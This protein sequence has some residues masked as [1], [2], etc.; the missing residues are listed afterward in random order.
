MAYRADLE[1]QAPFF[2]ALELLGAV[3]LL[4]YRARAF[5]LAGGILPELA[6]GDWLAGYTALACL[7]DGLAL[8][9]LLGLLLVAWLLSPLAG[10]LVSAL[11]L[12]LSAVGIAFMLFAADF[13][14]VYQTAFS[15]SFIGGE[16]FTGLKS[17]LQS[18]GSELSTASRLL[19]LAMLT[20]LALVAALAF[21]RR[22][23]ALAGALFRF[24]K[25]FS[26]LALSLAVLVSAVASGL[27]GQLVADG[28]R[29]SG[30]D[31]A[32]NPLSALLYGRSP[33]SAATARAVAPPAAPDERLVVEHARLAAYN[34]D[35]L[36]SP[37]AERYLPTLPKGPY[38]VILYF[39]E[40]T[41]WRYWDL[42]FGGQKLL[43]TMH[44]LAEHGLLLRNHY[45]NFPLSAN[46]MYSVLSSR[47][48]MYGKSMIF[49][50]YHDI[51][52]GTMMEVLSDN[53]Y[54]TGL[55]HT[56]DLQYAARDDFIAG[57]G[58]DHVV[59]YADLKRGREREA[60]V[61]WGA[62][63]RLMIEP[64]AEW[65]AGRT[66]P[67]FL[68][69]IPVNPHH[70]YAVPD[71]FPRLVD[72]DAPGLSDSERNWRNYL[73]SLHFADAAMGQLVDK[74]EK[75]G[76]MDNTVF[77]MVT[78][79]GEA[80]YQHR[81]NYNH[82]LFIYEENVHV[83]ALF[84]SPSLFPR[85]LVL[86]SVT[87]HV[88]IMPSL[89]DLLRIPDNRQRDGESIFSRSRQKMAVFHTAWNEEFMGVRDGRWKYIQRMADARDELYDL[90]AD[91]DEIQNLAG[92]YP[93]ITARYRQ[94]TN[95]M[96]DYLV[97]QY[98]DPPRR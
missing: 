90:S 57:R 50:E 77:V 98:R 20:S 16:H 40:S 36:E 14:R 93:E 69:V 73:N 67:Y 60:N 10:R 88:D 27:S 94:V 59:L 5:R 15:R 89:L 37:Q 30:A 71:D 46:T 52:V 70:P 62:D 61:G 66:T 79:H 3:S 87:R 28:F 1:R 63:E 9:S 12:A 51:D 18:A 75:R 41:S 17:I 19:L 83:P 48:S 95:G 86:E 11:A 91:P 39:F 47:Y 2:L 97:D 53:G 38:N 44:R 56:G 24:K 45:S 84:Y 43:P 21:S 34:T 76:A 32:A 23:A 49:G 72:A 13:L 8:A 64:A 85:P 92:Q 96:V 6:A 68:M 35:S 81:G 22:M 78:D 42:E 55:I 25:V 82:P 74:L 7:S 65:I 26:L 54:A 29:A 80:F 58:I 4:L 33:A 31:L